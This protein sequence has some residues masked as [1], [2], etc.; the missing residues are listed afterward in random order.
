MNFHIPYCSPISAS[1][2]ATTAIAFAIVASRIASWIN[3]N[4]KQE[5]KHGKKVEKCKRLVL[6]GDHVTSSAHASYWQ[7]LILILFPHLNSQSLSLLSSLPIRLA[8]LYIIRMFN[9]QYSIHNNSLFGCCFWFLCT[10]EFQFAYQAWWGQT[11]SG[12][13]KPSQAKASQARQSIV[14]FTWDVVR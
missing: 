3:F 5:R 10:F 1:T 9:I 8:N 7:M 11:R 13:T 12:Q 6:P 4:E 2:S 14:L